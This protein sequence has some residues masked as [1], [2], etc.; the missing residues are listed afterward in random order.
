VKGL[1]KMSYGRNPYYI[2]SDGQ[3]MCFNNIYV[4]EEILNA[5]LYKILLTERREELKERL[6]QGKESWLHKEMLINKHT[7]MRACKA[8][9]YKNPAELIFAEISQD[10]EELVLERKWMEECEDEIVKKLLE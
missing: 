6:K 5:F 1:N 8:E 2:W 9:D 7:G 4:P 3:N 10:D